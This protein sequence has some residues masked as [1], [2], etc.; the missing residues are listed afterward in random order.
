MFSWIGGKINKIQKPLFTN[1][2]NL[3]FN[4]GSTANITLRN[5]TSLSQFLAYDI[6]ENTLS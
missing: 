3:G 6:K 1:C 5:Q 4:G 2:L